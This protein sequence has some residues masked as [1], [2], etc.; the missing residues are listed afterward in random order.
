M[1]PHLILVLALSI[2]TVPPTTLAEA[3]TMY[4][5]DVL[6]LSLRSQPEASSERI[7]VLESGQKLEIVN[8]SGEWAMVRSS[9]EKTGWVRT[10][11]LTPDMTSAHKLAVLKKKH[12]ILVLQA[13]DLRKENT[14][15]KTEISQLRRDLEKNSEKLI[16]VEDSYSSLKS[17]SADYLKLKKEHQEAVTKLSEYTG[18]LENLETELANYELQR[19]VRWFLSGAGV[20]LLGLIIGFN[21]KRQ[22]RRLL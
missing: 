2:L 20:L 15:L 19:T 1:S 14:A 10:R 7:G 22:R 17:G 21:A 6:R 9:D 13:T 5:T 3:E 18:R 16:K 4:V 12:Q 11:F 8:A